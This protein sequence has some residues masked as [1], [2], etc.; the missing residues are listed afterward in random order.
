V[1][2]LRKRESTACQVRPEG[3]FTFDAVTFVA[4]NTGCLP[5]GFSGLG[6]TSLRGHIHLQARKQNE[7]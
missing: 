5:K 1:N 6:I 7:R 2:E 4:L 3:A